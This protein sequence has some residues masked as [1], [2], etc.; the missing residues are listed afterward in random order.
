[1][2][3]TAVE[4]EFSQ[5][6][7]LDYYAAEAP[8]RP[9]VVCIHGG[10]FISGSRQDARCL[11]SAEIL[12]PAGFNMASLSYSLA[13][14]DDRFG[15]WPRNFCNVVDA[16]AWLVEHA[17][18]LGFDASRIGLLGFSAGCCLSGLYCFGGRGLLTHVGHE[19]PWVEPACLF[20][21]Y[22]P[23]DFR[24]R[25]PERRSTDENINRDHSPAYW[26]NAG[27]DCT[28]PV[29]HVQGDEDVIVYPDQAGAF[30]ADYQALG[31]DF[32]ARLEPGFGH[33]FAP[34]DRNADGLEL[35]VSAEMLEFFRKHLG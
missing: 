20:G 16:M 23:Y 14:P 34:R 29:Y 33:S 30:E 19:A 6:L 4:H 17:E 13:S 8:V 25:Q 27:A 3:R 31:L 32:T 2:P 9:L 1:M 21:F 22:G 18:E 5:G 24:R 28:P 26:L 35:D 7:F 10:G 11:Q 12:V 15:M